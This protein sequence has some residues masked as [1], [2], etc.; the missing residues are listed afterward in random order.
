MSPSLLSAHNKI[1]GANLSTM[2]KLSA[3]K[4]GDGAL[5]T[6]STH[7]LGSADCAAWLSA[8]DLDTA[9]LAFYA[10]CGNVPCSADALSFE[11]DGTYLI[12]FKCGGAEKWQLV[13]KIY[14]GVMI[15]SE[16]DGFS[17]AKA[18]ESLFYIIVCARLQPWNAMRKVLGHA[19]AYCSDPWDRFPRQYDNWSLKSLEGVIARKIYTMPP[20]MFNAFAKAR[21][22][23]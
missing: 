18:R 23:R 6:D 3:R 22:W 1:F 7:A 9:K 13:R 20:D 19:E 21:R 8:V 5:P 11:R 16:H 17:Y 15:L 12:E 2:Y 4:P 10:P 14:D